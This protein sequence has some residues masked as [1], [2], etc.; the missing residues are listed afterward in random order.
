MLISRVVA[1]MKNSLSGFENAVKILDVKIKEGVK[2]SF[3]SFNDGLEAEIDTQFKALEHRIHTLEQSSGMAKDNNFLVDLVTA[4][5]A[6]LRE[7]LDEEFENSLKAM[8][9]EDYERSKRKLNVMVF[10]VPP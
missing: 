8:I 2:Y 10:G 1:R 4:K 6:I 7:A 9:A 3:T 5:V